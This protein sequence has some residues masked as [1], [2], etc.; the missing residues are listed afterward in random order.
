M[1]DEPLRHVD[2]PRHRFSYELRPD[3]AL[4]AAIRDLALALEHAGLLPAGAATA[5]RFQPHLTLLRAD[6][7]DH[8]A[9]AAVAAHASSTAALALARAGT[10][11]AGRIAWLAPEADAALHAA[12]AELVDRLGAA[13]VDPLALARDPWTP[14]VTVAYAVDELHRAAVLDAVEA[15]LPLHGRWRA[16]QCWDLDVRPTR[17]VAEAPVTAG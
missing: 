4:D 5:P 1:G 7:A 3:A 13:H 11:G 17:C 16:A 15:A 10:F 9:L 12:R 14:H 6:R 8:A 2:D